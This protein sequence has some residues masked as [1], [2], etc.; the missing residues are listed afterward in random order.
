MRYRSLWIRAFAVAACTAL[1]LSA[2]CNNGAS[3][4]DDDDDDDD[5]DS[6]EYDGGNQDDPDGGVDPRDPDGSVDP[7]DP[8]GGVD[9]GD[10]DSGVDPGEPDAGGNNNGCQGSG[11]AAQPFGNHAFSY[12][13]GTILPHGSQDSRDD[14]VRDFYDSWKSNYLRSGCGGYYVDYNGNDDTVS[15]AHGYGMLI[16]VYM[17]GYDSQAKQ[18]FDGM[19]DYFD[20]HRSEIQPQLMAWKQS[21]CNN[22]DGANS[23]TDGDLDIA[24]A[25]LV[26]DKQWGSDGDIDYRARG[27]EVAAGIMEAD[28]D[29]SHRFLLVGDWTQWSEEFSDAT[30][31]S[32]FMPGHLASFASAAG[33]SWDQLLDSQ[34]D[35]LSEAQTS[36]APDTGLLADFYIHPIDSIDTPDGELLE[37]SGDDDYEY[38][39]CR[40]PWRI[41]THFVTSGDNRSRQMAQRIT[42]WVKGETGSDPENVRAGYHLDGSPL[43]SS[44]YTDL[45]FIAPLGVGAMVDSGNQA[46]LNNVWDFVVDTGSQGYYA[47][48]IKLLSMIVM[49]G[50]W[51]TPEQAPC[52]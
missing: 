2:G 50:N 45:A 24:Y 15:E 40:D 33:G 14:A 31:S 27:L 42:T 7:R 39:A 13:S 26:A 3:S 10:P 1:T 28:V 18:I 5:D 25:L 21:N 51:W 46:W 17:A 6:T 44:N 30:R 16:A 48:S 43:P 36:L 47:D 32:D 52:D 49:S 9:P 34:Y 29:P 8:D 41:A 11:G 20:G 4:D 23:A 12:A 37:D 38:N 19:Y 22:V 35:F